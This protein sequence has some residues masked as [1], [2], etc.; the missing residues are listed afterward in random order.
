MADKKYIEPKQG[1]LK[2]ND[3]VKFFDDVT[4]GGE[5]QQ[6]ILSLVEAEQRADRV[7]FAAFIALHKRRFQ[8]CQFL[9]AHQRSILVFLG[10]KH[11]S[12]LQ[13]DANFSGR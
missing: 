11:P 10:H 7:L 3:A 1:E 9:V 13:L 6:V 8:R 4:D 2:A 5:N 12:F